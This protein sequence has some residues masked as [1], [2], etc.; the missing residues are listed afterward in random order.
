MTGLLSRALALALVA[1]C[2]A[3][4]AA[5]KRIAVLV[6]PLDQSSE[7]ASVQ[8][9]AYIREA[10]SFFSSLTVKR[11]EELFG[12]PPDADAQAALAKAQKLTAEARAAFD[13]KDGVTCD[14][15][16]KAALHAFSKASAAMKGCDSYCE[17]LALTAGLAHA[18][19]E[20]DEAR[21]ALL[22]LLA[23]SPDYELDK[24]RFPQDF[25]D[26]RTTVQ[27]SRSA[28]LRGAL[29]IKSQ[30][31]GARIYLD[32]EPKGFTPATV[33]NLPVGKH[34]LKLE[35]PGFKMY[36]ALVEVTLEDGEVSGALT[37]T[38]AYQAYD[39]V[40]AGLVREARSGKGGPVVQALGKTLQVD[41]AIVALVKGGG[42]GEGERTELYLHLFD[43]KSGQQLSAKKANFQGDEYGQLKSETGRVVN[44]LLVGDGERPTAGSDPLR[45][46]HGTEDW[47]REDRGGVR[48]KVENKKK[49]DDPLDGVSG[50]EDW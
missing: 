35:R 38:P 10:L 12:M 47:N 45:G 7:T 37:P 11:G 43:L 28:S 1:T 27:Q 29:T 4:V 15:K 2:S 5:P 42:A 46:R 30:P 18:R 20:G 14:K 50:T 41:R 22:D 26:L 23:V 16:L 36:G 44:A 19:G 48:S 24:R 49:G 39:K 25:V 33:P 9:E 13:A 40:T 34:L 6:L 17:A 8:F 32:G 31:P 21:I 3:A